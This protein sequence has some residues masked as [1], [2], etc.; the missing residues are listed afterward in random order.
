MVHAAAGCPL[1]VA[2]PPSAYLREC[3]PRQRAFLNGSVFRPCPEPD[4]R[5]HFI[6][7]YPMNRTLFLA[8][9]LSKCTF[10]VNCAMQRMTGSF[11]VVIVLSDGEGEQF[12]EV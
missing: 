3:R 2:P 5:V 12:C 6:R 4:R 11:E 1:T 8:T 9:S 7:R 10:S